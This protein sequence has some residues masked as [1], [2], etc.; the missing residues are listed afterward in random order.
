MK[1]LLITAVA[2]W[3]ASAAHS[4]LPRTLYVVNGSAETLS[5]INLETGQVSNHIITLGVVPNQVV[6]KGKKAYVVNSTSSNIQK[7][8]LTADTIISYIFLGAGKNPWNIAF[9]DT[10]YAY[11]TNF[12]ANSISKIDV[13]ND[14]VLGEF[15]IGQ[16]PEGLTFYKN[17]LYVCNTGFNP[18][19]FSY[20]PGTVAVFDPQFDSVVAGI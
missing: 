8:D 5:K 19:D 10:Q 18:N 16:S 7:I 1:K 20:G 4:P 17:K 12:S 15:Q 3:L 2:L 13:I 11:V 9:I 14:M 6:V